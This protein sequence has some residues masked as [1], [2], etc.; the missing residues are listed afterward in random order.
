[1]LGTPDDLEK[2]IT[3]LN[4]K[5]GGFGVFLDMAHNWADFEQTKRSYELI[6]RYVVPRFSGTAGR[7]DQADRWAME[8]KPELIER[9]QAGVD[10]AIQNHALERK[11]KRD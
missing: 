9:R 2:Q 4:E 11:A 5:S 10:R 1:M 6:A 8:K 3:R 7:Q